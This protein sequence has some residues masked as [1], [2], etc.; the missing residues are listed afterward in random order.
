MENVSQIINWH[1]K[2]VTKT[3]TRPISTCSCRER[4]NCPMD[5]NCRVEN[6]VYKCV[7]SATAKLKEHVCVGV[8]MGDWKQWHYNHTMS[9]RNQRYKNDKTL[10]TFVW[11]LKKS[12]KEIPKYAWS[13]LKVVSGYSNIS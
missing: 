1:N 10:S 3:N 12:T 9:F 13:V 5:G 11:E 8:T 2:R 7:V 6:V 4:N